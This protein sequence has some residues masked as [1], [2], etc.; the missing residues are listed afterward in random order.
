[1]GQSRCREYAR[2]ARGCCPE[3]DLR[4]RARGPSLG[5]IRSR[6]TPSLARFKRALAQELGYAS[7][8]L[9][10]ELRRLHLIIRVRVLCH[11]DAFVDC[12]NKSLVHALLG[13]F[14][15]DSLLR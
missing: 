14:V 15:G 1:M 3:G 10:Q 7:R 8:S 2:A 5:L 9:A 13:R 4:K 6:S 11:L 12:R